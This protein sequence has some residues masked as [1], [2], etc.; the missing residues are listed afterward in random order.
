MTLRGKDVWKEK[1]EAILIF[2]A[3]RRGKMVV[4]SE[5]GDGKALGRSTA[6]Q[7]HFRDES[8]HSFNYLKQW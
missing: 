1:S 4:L 3:C 8:M 5:Y 7:T 2:C 6:L